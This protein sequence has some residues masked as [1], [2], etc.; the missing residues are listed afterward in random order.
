MTS[1]SIN[2][3]CDGYFPIL[4]SIDVISAVEAVFGLMSFSRKRPTT[5]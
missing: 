5:K 4:T 1:D 2:I 3:F